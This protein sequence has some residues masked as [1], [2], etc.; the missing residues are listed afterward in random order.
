[1]AHILINNQELENI[2]KSKYIS[3]GD[4]GCC[5]YYKGLIYKIYHELSSSRNIYFN[6][7]ITNNIAF[8]KDILMSLEDR[9]IIGYTMNLLCGKNLQN[10]FLEEL[11]LENLKKAYQNIRNEIEK[12]S[13]ID[14]NNIS[15]TNI[16]FDYE[17]NS[18]N[19]IDT[20]LWTKE[21]YIT[22]NINVE[23]FNS[24]LIKALSITL[25]WNRYFLNSEP[26]LFD[27]YGMYLSGQSYFIE[28]LT[29]IE[30]L[31]SEIKGKKVLK[32]K[33]IIN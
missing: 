20:S 4:E 29:E 22:S 25:D 18:F 32:I 10:G 17:K 12:F 31:N 15:L 8:P 13:Y 30:E 7:E 1:M 28:F 33:D 6:L 19:L 23:R 3:S 9:K 16:L 24:M 26:I 5:Y 2:R 11:S 21:Q 14:M 27:L